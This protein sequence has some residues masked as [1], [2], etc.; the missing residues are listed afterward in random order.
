MVVGEHQEEV[1]HLVVMEEE[2]LLQLKKMVLLIFH[3][4]FFLMTQKFFQIFP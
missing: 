4:S 2:V 1:E 3:L